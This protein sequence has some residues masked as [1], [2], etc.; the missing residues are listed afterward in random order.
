MVPT[1]SFDVKTVLMIVGWVLTAASLYF[2]LSNK[3]DSQTIKL[4]AQT[5]TIRALEVKQAEMDASSRSLERALT[6]LT[7]T[8]RVKE[9]LK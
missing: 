3:I 5:V 9:I 1:L 4:D 8:L 7:V 6:E 2:G